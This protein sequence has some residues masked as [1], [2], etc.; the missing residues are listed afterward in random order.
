MAN[1]Q[2][3]PTPQ[4][5]PAVP[6]PPEDDVPILLHEKGF[7]GILA[8]AAST[9][10]ADIACGLT[11]AGLPPW[12]PGRVGLVS[13]LLDGPMSQVEIART[14]RI[15][16]PSA[17][18]LVKR[19]ERDG[20]VER[21]WDEHDARRRVVSLTP[22]ARQQIIEM[23][24]EL[25]RGMGRIEGRMAA[26]GFDQQDIDRCKALLEAFTEAAKAE[27][28]YRTEAGAEAPRTAAG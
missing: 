16:P 24:R 11:Q 26:Q 28:A 12:G 1:H 4:H 25:L 5:A 22:S 19:L 15:S 7:A 18:E 9:L 13:K 17:M 10:R 8:K 6:L 21:T 20:Y 14:L 2:D 3:T 27:I 23:R